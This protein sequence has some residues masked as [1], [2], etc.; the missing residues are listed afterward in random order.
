MNILP[1]L[2]VMKAGAHS[3]LE[4]H[5]A[6]TIQLIARHLVYILQ[7]LRRQLES[8]R[9]SSL[10]CYAQKVRLSSGRESM[11]QV[12]ALL[13]EK[14]TACTAALVHA[15][16]LVQESVAAIDISQHMG[17]ASRKEALQKLGDGLRTWHAQAAG[18]QQTLS[19]CA[20]QSDGTSY[21]VRPDVETVAVEVA[22]V[23]QALKTLAVEG[24]GQLAEPG[25]MA[26]TSY[27]QDGLLELSSMG[28]LAQAQELL[29]GAGNAAL[30]PRSQDELAS[31]QMELGEMRLDAVMLQFRAIV[32]NVHRKLTALEQAAPSDD[33]ASGMGEFHSSLLST[34]QAVS[35]VNASA[36]RLAYVV[37]SVFCGLAMEGFCR[38]QDD[39]GELACM[40]L[41][42][43]LLNKPGQCIADRQPPPP[44]CNPKQM[45]GSKKAPLAK[46]PGWEKAPPRVRK[47]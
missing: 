47:T 3:D 36:S 27:V 37:T 29:C 31:P 15:R 11:P 24:A 19:L 22:S 44:C 10:R 8:S 41:Q 25:L 17:P 38:P 1:L 23:L 33:S 32:E 21:V 14:F 30:D 42:A 20:V 34:S 9:R 16:G 18:L 4:Q 46:A 2:Q 45:R 35:A 26:L 28:S 6:Q 40:G 5:Q 43:H 12:Q 39:P 7:Q 13:Q